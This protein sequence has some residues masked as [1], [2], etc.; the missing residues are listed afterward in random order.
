MHFEFESARERNMKFTVKYLVLHFLS[1]I[2]MAIL[3]EF[4]QKV[5]VCHITRRYTLIAKSEK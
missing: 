1:K 3:L 4:V 2:Q 5:R